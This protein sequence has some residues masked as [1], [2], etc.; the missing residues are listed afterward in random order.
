VST[1]G[2]QRF[3]R[4]MIEK[5]SEL[6][7]EVGEVYARVVARC[8]TSDLECETRP[9]EIVDGTADEDPVEDNEWQMNFVQNVVQQLDKCYA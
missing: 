6:G 7:Q 5:A 9:T 8:L 2:R 3:R 4:A 1:E